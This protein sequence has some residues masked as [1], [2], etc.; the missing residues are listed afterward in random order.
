MAKKQLKDYVFRPGVGATSYVYPDGYSLLNSNKEFIQKESSAWIATQVAA[1]NTYSYAETVLTANKNFIADEAVAW[2][3]ANN[4]GIH[5]DTR[6]EKCERDTK[7]NIDA[8]V[9][10]LHTGGNS[11]TIATVK[12]YWEGA[13]SQLGAGE[14]TYALSVNNKVE[15]IIN[16]YVLTNKAYTTGQSGH[17]LAASDTVNLFGIKTNCQF[18]D[19]VYPQ[20]PFS[21]MFR[22][23]KV[24]DANTVEFFL[25]T[26][27]IDHVYVA[28]GQIFLAAPTNVGGATNISTFE[29]DNTTGL[30]TIGSNVHGLAVGD[31]VQL[32]NI[33]VSCLYGSKVYPDTSTTSGIFVVYDVIDNDTFVIGMDKSKIVHTYV[34]G[35]TVQ[36][37]NVPVSGAVNITGFIFDRVQGIGRI[38]AA[39]HGRTVG[40]MIE[41]ENVNFTCSLGAKTYPVTSNT[42]AFTVRSQNLSTT[43]F[44]VDIGTSGVTQTYVSGGIVVKSGGARLPVSDFNYNT[45]TGIA[46]ITTAT[47]QTIN[48]NTVSAATYTPATGV[49]VLTIGAHSYELNDYIMIAPESLTFTCDLDS[50]ATQHSYPRATGSSAP[51]GKDYAYN[52]PV[53]ITATGATTITVNV[54][55]SSDTSTHTFVSAT[56]G[57]ISES[58]SNSAADRVKYLIG[59][60]NDVT[61][62]GL[63]AI[64]TGQI[65]SVSA[66]TYTPTT[67]SMQLTI[68]SHGYQIGDTIRIA[69]ESLT[70][71]CA[72]DGHGTQHSYPRASGSTAPS[73]ADY[74]YNSLVFITAIGAATITV[75][76]GISSDTSTHTFV[77]ATAGCITSPPATNSVSTATY[78][79]AT[80]EMQLTIGT[81]SYTVGSSIRIAPASLTFTCALDSHASNHTYPRA[82]GSS[83]PGGKDYAYNAPLE[84]SVVN[85]DTITVNVGISSDTS[86]HTFVSATAN[87][88]TSDSSAWSNFSYVVATCERD[89]GYLLDAYL[90]DL[91]YGGTAETCKIIGFYW[92]EEV[93]Q[94][95]GNRLPEINTHEFIRDLINNYVLTN[96]AYSTTQSTASQ[97]I[98]LS[99]TTEAN[100]TSRITSLTGIVINVITNGLTA[101]PGITP[102]GVGT[103]RIQ[104]RWDQDNLLL[105]TNTTD[106]ITIYNFV[107][108]ELGGICS[109]KAGGDDTDFPR[110]LQVTDTITTITLNTDTSTQAGTD[111]L[112]IFVEEEKESAIKTDAIERDRVSTALAMLDADFEYGLQPTKWSA[113]GV[114]RG[115]PSIYEIPG[116]NTEVYNITSDASSG[117]GGVGQSLVTV[118][119]QGPHGFIET[120][121]VTVKALENSV[122]GASRAEGSFVITT[123]PTSTSFT[124]YSKAK[125]GTSNGDVLLTSYTQLRKAA[126]YTGASIGSPTFSVATQGSGGTMTVELDV[127]SG[128]TIIPYDGQTPGTGS[129]LVSAS[130]P[131]GS[132]VT[133]SIEQSA[134]GGT[135][136]TPEISGDYISG[137]SSI[138]FVDSTGIL[139]NLGADSGNGTVTYVETVNH[140]SNTITL[141]SPLTSSLI[142]NTTVYSSITGTNVAPIGTNVEVSIDNTATTYSVTGIT[143]PGNDYSVGDNLQIPGTAL[144]GINVVNDLKLRVATLTGASGG[145]A[146]LDV[147]TPNTGF[148]G[149]H[150]FTD[151]PA[152]NVGGSGTGAVFDVVYEDT[153][154]TS[155]TLAA[156]SVDV[157]FT[158]NDRLV[159]T[160]TTLSTAGVDLVNDLVILVTGVGG[161]GDITGFTF[162]GLAPHAQQIYNNPQ[163]TTSGGGSQILFEVTRTGQ[164]DSAGSSIGIYSLQFTDYGTGFANSDT[165][166][167]AGVELG[168]DSSATYDLEI[169]VTG[170][171]GSGT[172]TAYSPVGLAVNTDTKLN[173]NANALIG[174]G[175]EF[176]V[177]IA[178]GNYTVTGPFT[179]NGGVG[180]GVGQELLI[181]GNLLLGTSP[182][183]DLT[184]TVTSVVA[185]DS[186][187]RG[188][189]LTYTSAGSAVTNTGS[190]TGIQPS[191]VPGS[192]SGALF[193]I[194]RANTV[195]SITAYE[196]STGY[197]IGDRL[198][199]AGTLLGGGTPAHDL[200]LR[201]TSV[202]G[203]NVIDGATIESGVGTP[204]SIF[205]LICT[206]TM[207]EASSSILVKGASVVFEALASITI[208]FPYA[209]GLVPGSSFITTITSDDASNNHTLAAG[210]TR[211]TNIP[212]EKQLTYQARSG[213]V[214]DVSGG[215]IIGYVYPRPDSFF[216]H[217]PFDGGVMLGT[218]GPQHA[219]QAIRQSKKYLRYQSGK[220]VMYTTGAMFAPSYE[221]KSVTADSLEV[222]ALITVVTDDNDHGVQIGGIIRLKGIDTPGYNSGPETATPPE[223]DYEVV[224][225]TDERT[226]KIRAQ[227]RLGA[228]EA[229]FGFNAQMSVV[230]WHGST[231]R[232][233]T[234]DDQNGTFWEYDGTQLCVVQRTGTFQLAGTVAVNADSNYVTGVGTRFIDQ[235]ATG[236]RIIIKGMTHVVTH[237]K[238][239]TAMCINPDFRGVVNVTGAKAMRV[240]DKRIK[241]KDFNLD[242]F[243]GKGASGFELDPARMQMIGIQWA[244][245]GAGRID[246]W[247][248]KASGKMISAHGIRGSNIN[249]EAYMRSGNLPVRYEVTNEGPPG[250]LSEAIDASQTTIKI[251]DASFFP[252]SGV[253]YIDNE[254][255]SYDGVFE[256]SLLNCVRGATYTNFQAG[257][258]RSYTAAAATTHSNK[259]GIVLISNT[260]TPL[261]SHW[262]SSYLMDG[263]FDFD[264]G[265][266]FSYAETNISVTTVKQTAFLL[267]LSPSVS[268]A[269]VGDL[270][271][272][273]LLNRAQLLLYGIE[274]TSDTGTGGFIIEGVINPQNYPINPV[275]IG[276]STLSGLAQGGQPSFAQ[277]A[278][279]G[280]VVWSTGATPTTSTATAV[281]TVTGV[282]DSGQY[283]NWNGSYYVY[284]SATD[285]RTTFGS[286]SLDI[287]LGKSISGSGIQTGTIIDGGYIS[288]YDNYGYFYLNLRT[289]AQV[290][291]NTASAFTVTNNPA[292]TNANKAFF[293]TTSFLASGAAGGTAVTNGGSVTFPPS[294]FVNTISLKEWAGTEYYEVT[295]NNAFSGTLANGSGT[296]EFTFEQPPY[297][298]PGETVFS[299][300]A[301]PGERST[302]DLAEM[303]ELTNTPIGGRGT[304][305]NGPDV[306]AIN[307]YKIS[308]A[309]VTA[310]I[311]LKWG[312]AQA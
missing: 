182:A 272:R 41:V 251:E 226:F 163:W 298:L 16:D 230:H 294:T 54:G 47:S 271:E 291:Q 303:K 58:D 160:G 94:I 304:F 97:V 292:L 156:S 62:N 203:G 309:A 14:V 98:D 116:T 237:V 302:L 12:K 270:G 210:S 301:V 29:F 80:G 165:I 37:V 24:P 283:T 51:G 119:T 87:C 158:V 111:D 174:S 214:I 299:F 222:N 175:V 104:G 35:G 129:P 225:V 115:Y 45:V 232:A 306:L 305:P 33:T 89:V 108:P 213:G 88:I 92:D 136:L 274:V 199:I 22:I 78:T 133:G 57:G 260:I 221:L 112:Q 7:Y 102:T 257:A 200:I 86:V 142:G 205:D 32:E 128:N 267:R 69:T 21:G 266:I 255:I 60:I 120:D 264:R 19:K 39:A 50:H 74:A 121:P 184:I 218:G 139:V 107:T 256:N 273:E 244:W 279:G 254:I 113:I 219:A 144:G 9:A 143:T 155:V 76:V 190:F 208:D 140:P 125:V 206:F 101:L 2:F 40:D 4:P 149:T 135:Y 124:Y 42:T 95:D 177:D 150:T 227:R 183:N 83:A 44:E 105:I 153:V 193:Q 117:T 145:I 195:Y 289:T 248:R 151:V 18:G 235:L 118:T 188:E 312:E 147:I 13:S 64:P 25:P 247:A 168:G 220:G 65:Y 49:M 197:T 61:E 93:A 82:T 287:V 100:V 249:T 278:S 217:R 36:K 207:T 276:W 231:V 23:T 48:A 258:S 308:G 161:G 236:D 296:V 90:Y 211:A 277:V 209:H 196:N 204:G 241:Q 52:T 265:Y 189:V 109:Y 176:T 55:I 228:V 252:T 96:T 192:G 1:A 72:K 288:D 3:D 17:G 63:D 138:T 290:A 263:G 281:A 243:D 280:S 167:I 130:I 307:I 194:T 253:L 73:G 245:Y 171:D 181:A 285:Y 71:T 28:G 284:V 114:L 262:G 250:K 131:T 99:K 38:T 180:Y 70:F 297:A 67:G 30:T 68:G 122:A 34:S 75:D 27:E 20:I 53:K 234:Y 126:F 212:T 59:I 216:V 223:F 79:P 233:G 300:I 91:R 178:G 179:P 15:E 84:I 311:V 261:I 46:T 186:T 31:A 246:F 310:N 8:I 5:N 269:I 275:D 164:G 148:N 295:F 162:S 77:S 123:V 146:S 238:N 127:P 170:V 201:V 240:T 110:Y 85:G 224:N 106:N 103:I 293:D 286:N 134:G 166:D 154:F 6:H 66:A 132:Q 10:D 152:A 282:L 215:D 268:N 229:V 43:T 137:T 242:T 26:S 191:T 169:T 81:H 198:S 239:Q 187:G 185:D 159:I 11:E 173:I 141:T 157:N 202:A 172:I 56:A 259:T